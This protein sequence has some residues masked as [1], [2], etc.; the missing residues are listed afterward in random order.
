MSAVSPNIP[1][2]ATAGSNNIRGM[3]FLW[4]FWSNFGEKFTPKCWKVFLRENKM[5][6]FHV[7]II[8]IPPPHGCM[9][10]SWCGIGRHLKT[11]PSLA[12][13]LRNPTLTG[14]KFVP[15]SIP[16]SCIFFIHVYY[17]YTLTL[18]SVCVPVWACGRRHCLSYTSLFPIR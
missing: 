6:R 12:Q 14:T 4:T 1:G 8:K 3:W 17:N 5:A 16:L 9:L 10:G 11:L 13:N 2:V 7:Q 18:S 15:K